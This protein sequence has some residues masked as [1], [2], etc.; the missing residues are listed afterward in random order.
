M[1]SNLIPSKDFA[2]YKRKEEDIHSNLRTFHGP[3]TT[4]VRRP[5]TIDG[6]IDRGTA[7]MQV[8]W[9][10]RANMY[11]SNHSDS[12]TCNLYPPKRNEVKKRKC[13]RASR[14][15]LPRT[16]MATRDTDPTPEAA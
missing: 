8:H 15:P 3:K 5:T 7:S 9:R 10:R 14:T 11:A 13:R 16:K 1:I 12:K 2:L 6:R 4:I